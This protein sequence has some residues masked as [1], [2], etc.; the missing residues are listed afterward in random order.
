MSGNGIKEAFKLFAKGM[1]FACYVICLQV[2]A[3]NLPLMID[4]LINAQPL[5]NAQ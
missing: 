3:Y 5:I 2:E 4:L 1:V